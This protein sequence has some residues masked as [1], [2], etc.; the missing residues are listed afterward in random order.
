MRIFSRTLSLATRNNES[1][2]TQRQNYYNIGITKRIKRKQK[3]KGEKQG[4]LRHNRKKENNTNATKT[5]QVKSA[6]SRKNKRI[7][8]LTIKP[9]SISNNAGNWI[10]LL[11]RNCSHNFGTWKDNK[12][13][14][15]KLNKS[16]E[17]HKYCYIYTHT[18]THT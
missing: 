15:V 2:A 4:W 13:K 11:N 14:Q 9:S 6:A 17:S 7:T 3:K 1:H 8:A 10:A 16:T 18:H 12:D 5:I